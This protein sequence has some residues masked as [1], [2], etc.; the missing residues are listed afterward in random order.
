MVCRFLMICAVTLLAPAIGPAQVRLGN[1]TL[2]AGGF[3]ELQGKR[4]GLLTNPS[5]VNPNLQST[6]DLLRS[7]RGV[8]LAALFA[9]EHGLNADLPAGQEFPSGTDA[10]TGL[11]VYSLYG[12]G[13]ARKPTPAM[14]KGLDA[15][16]YDLQ[17]TGCRSYTFIST[18]GLAMEACAT[19]GVEFI[20]LDRPNPLGGEHVEGPRLDPA[21]RSLVGQ[22]PIPYVYGLTAGELARMINGEGWIAKPCKLTVVPL[23]NWR[24]WMVWRDTFLPWVPTSP[25]LPQADSPMH[26]VATGLLGHIGGVSIGIGYTLPFQCLAAP[27]LPAQDT[28]RVLN[29]YALPGTRFLPVSY[30]PFAGAFKEQNISGVQM[31]FT[32]PGRA[33]L[34]A[35]NFYALEAVRKLSG[36]DLFAAALKDP[37]KMSLFDKLMGTDATRRALEGGASAASVVSSWKPDEES[38]RQRRQ[39]YLLY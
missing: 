34:M 32:E 33:R 13:P 11:P 4:V 29:S 12:P 26:Y 18:M 22:W 1:E 2:A 39:K 23:Q 19:N 9:P 6:V 8:T 20:V 3:K 7:A 37:A 10:R 27:W 21:F 28:A 38:F 30:K 35:V 16:V 17:D 14:L 36:K 5:G 31:F 25:H 24:R 15:L